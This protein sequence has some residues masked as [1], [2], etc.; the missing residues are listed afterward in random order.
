MGIENVEMGNIRV[1]LPFLF[2][3]WNVL[4]IL[5]KTV[6]RIAL[7]NP[8]IGEVNS[9]VGYLIDRF[10]VDS[11]MVIHALIGFITSC[12]AYKIV[13]DKRL[14]CE[15]NDMSPERVFVV[16]NIIFYIVVINNIFW[17]INASMVKP[18]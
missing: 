5:D 4:N 1:T 17:V 8:R 13:T 15:K 6:T 11:A 10:G 3:N 18:V 14:T 12:I 2:V 9:I 16:L 7:E